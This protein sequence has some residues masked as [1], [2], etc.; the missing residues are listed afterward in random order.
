MPAC[1]LCEKPY[2][3]SCPRCDRT[4]CYYDCSRLVLVDGS[5]LVWMCKKCAAEA[6]LS[7]E[8]EST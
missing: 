5:E 7:S 3:T 2:G 6:V 4:V 8:G 1:E